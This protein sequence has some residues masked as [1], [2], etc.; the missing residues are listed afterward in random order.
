M[1]Q[2]SRKRGTP[3]HPP[4]RRAAV[5]MRSISGAA[6][7]FAYAWRMS[8]NRSI[9]LLCL[10]SSLAITSCSSG[11]Y[12]DPSLVMDASVGSADLAQRVDLATA[13]DL[14]RKM[15]RTE[16]SFASPVTY[17]AGQFAYHIAVGRIDLDD[18]DDLLVSG[19]PGATVYLSAGDGTLIPKPLSL[20]ANW[21]VAIADMNRDGK[22]DLLLTNTSTGSIDV[23]LGN[24]DGTFRTP[25]AVPAG[26]A[27]QS[28]ASV[29][30]NGDGKPDLLTADQN[31]AELYAYVG[32]GD[33]TFGTPQ[34]L[35]TDK[36]GAPLWI[37]TGDLN[38]DGRIDAAVANLSTANIS[39]FFGKGDGTF[40]PAQQLPTIASPCDVELA[41]LNLDG[42]LDLAVNGEGVDKAVAVHLSDGKG[43]FLPLTKYPYKDSSGQ[44]LDLADLNQDGWPELIAIS[45]FSPPARVFLGAGNG[46]FLPEQTFNG[47]G[48][49]PFN[50][51]AVDLNRDGKRDL[52]LSEGSNQKISVLINTTP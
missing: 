41:D 30:L 7:C 22:G 45:A 31:A 26:K 18:K 6:L 37:A 2:P 39:L 16:L 21:Q 28:V 9:Q 23:V 5:A 24:G 29:D 51:R 15:P 8:H 13:P 36:A 25:L 48:G 20:L 35:I 33:G 19:R 27:P 11:G 40:L 17:P 32:N 47:S 49:N 50:V 1:A 3:N 4:H 38:R 42:N 10:V 34:R 44:G 12:V 43:G 14:A 52:V 46:T